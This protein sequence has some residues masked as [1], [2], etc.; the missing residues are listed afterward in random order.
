MRLV[1]VPAFTQIPDG[2]IRVGPLRGP[3]SRVRTGF[4]R[5]GIRLS[6]DGSDPVMVSRHAQGLVL[7]CAGPGVRGYLLDRDGLEAP[8]SDVD[9][10]MALLLPD[11]STCR[12]TGHYRAEEDRMVESEALYWRVSGEVLSSERRE[13]IGTDGTRRL[14]SARSAQAPRR[15]DGRGAGRLIAV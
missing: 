15:R 4:T 11:R 12:F 5:Y 8:S 7:S 3:I 6:L 13:L 10:L 2:R 1:P 14:L 9:A